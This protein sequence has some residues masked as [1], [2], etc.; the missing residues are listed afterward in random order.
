MNNTIKRFIFGE[1]SLEDAIREEPRI[2]WIID[3]IFRNDQARKGDHPHLLLGTKAIGEETGTKAYISYILAR[4]E[5]DGYIE[6]Y[7]LPPAEASQYLNPPRIPLPTKKLRR[8]YEKVKT[9]L[10]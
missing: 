1:I 10:K 3:Q 5:R 7:K 4:L 6:F 9:D 8:L 2:R